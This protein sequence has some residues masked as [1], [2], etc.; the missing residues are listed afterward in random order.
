MRT[1]MSISPLRED[2]YRTAQQAPPPSKGRASH[3]V[4]SK[5][6]QVTSRVKSVAS[7]AIGLIQIWGKF[8]SFFAS[9]LSKGG[10]KPPTRSSSLLSGKKVSSFKM[11][12]PSF[13]SAGVGAAT[14]GSKSLS[15][16]K[17]K[18]N[19]DPDDLVPS[20]PPLAIMRR[21]EDIAA[22]NPKQ[23]IKAIFEQSF[24]HHVVTKETFISSSKT[25]EQLELD[26]N[27]NDICICGVR[28]KS[29]EEFT[30][31]LRYT[32]FAGNERTL[33][34]MLSQA[35]MA[36]SYNLMN[37]YGTSQVNLLYPLEEPK[38]DVI[39]LNAYKPYHVD[40]S[41]KSQEADSD[42]MIR[43]D[44]S[45]KPI[46]LS[47]KFRGELELAPR[48]TFEYSTQ[49]PVANA[50]EANWSDLEFLHDLHLN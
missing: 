11:T 25:L 12:K 43:G 33:A 32:P 40:F 31:A 39:F 18:S 49:I 26:L 35:G 13:T 24:P 23:V 36:P 44:M 10:K 15:S 16:R 42:W 22:T 29:L 8:M 41:P 37:A 14:V 2:S 28:I 38:I 7:S 27:R 6:Q 34:E 20:A 30:H 1:T 48:V 5:L 46:A 4:H 9:L 47:D 45:F 17:R 19:F 21:T 50:R 3:G